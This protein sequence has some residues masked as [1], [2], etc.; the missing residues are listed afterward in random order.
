LTANPLKIVHVITALNTG[1]A[2]VML[3]KIIKAIDERE[4][5]TTVITLKSGGDLV[6]H[7]RDMGIKVIE[8][9]IGDTR[10]PI[11]GFFGLWRQLRKIQPD[12]VQTWLYHADMLGYFAGRLAGVKAVAWNIRCSDMGPDYYRGVVGAIVRLNSF[13]SKRLEAIVTNSVAGRKSHEA[14]GFKSSNWQ[15]IPNGFDLDMLRPDPSTRKFVRDELGLADSSRVVGLVARLDPVKGHK[16]FLRA[17]SKLVEQDDDIHFV[18]VGEGCVVGEENFDALV[19]P[20]LGKRLI[21][22][23]KRSDIAKINQAFDVAVSASLT[24]GFS[25]TIGEAMACGIPCVV[26][27]AGDN[28]AIVG[29]SGVVVPAGDP[30][31]MAS[32]IHELMGMNSDNRFQLGRQARERIANHYSIAAVARQY[33]DFYRSL[34]ETVPVP[35]SS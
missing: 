34:V 15:L 17:A 11:A 19:P 6:P 26:T 7:I 8:L 4:F 3:C 23:G 13:L 29:D 31:A 1:G 9:G 25:N 27:D 5:E 22:L 32:A 10:S 20:N 33:S 14:R 2:E 18:V 21:A 24:E 16:T 35:T 12:V 28:A 30:Q